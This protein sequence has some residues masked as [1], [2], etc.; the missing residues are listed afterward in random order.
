MVVKH[1]YIYVK[2]VDN[3]QAVVIFFEEPIG[4]LFN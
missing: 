4:I 1:D 2:I 3:C